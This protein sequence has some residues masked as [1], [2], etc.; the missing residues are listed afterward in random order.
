MLDVEDVVG[1]V[2]EALRDTES[3]GV[4]RSAEVVET[5]SEDGEGIIDEL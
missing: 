4:G 3:E 1:A 5:D 2:A